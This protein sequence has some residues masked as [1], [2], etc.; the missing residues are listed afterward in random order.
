MSARS[1]PRIPALGDL[2]GTNI[3]SIKP[4]NALDSDQNGGIISTSIQIKKQV[5]NKMSANASRDVSEETKPS[6]MDQH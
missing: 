4:D 6:I 1:K 3:R 2:T 5:T